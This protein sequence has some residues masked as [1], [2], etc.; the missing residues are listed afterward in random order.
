VLVCPT[1]C[2][3]FHT[4]QST[5]KL[6]QSTCNLLWLTLSAHVTHLN[7]PAKSWLSLARLTL[8]AAC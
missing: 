1:F 3:A 5:D 6:D 4:A 8:S 7:V 2:L